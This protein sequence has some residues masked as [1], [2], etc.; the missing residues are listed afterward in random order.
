MGYPSGYLKYPTG[1][2][3]MAF[4]AGKAKILRGML[5]EL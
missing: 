5:N 3:R 2:E 1:V 4:E